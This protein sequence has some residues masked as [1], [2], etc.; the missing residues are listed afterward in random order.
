MARAVSPGGHSATGGPYPLTCRRCPEG[1]DG[2]PSDHSPQGSSGI[3]Q[4]SASQTSV[5]LLLLED[6]VA[7]MLEQRKVMLV[8]TGTRSDVTFGD[9]SQVCVTLSGASGSGQSGKQIGT[10]GYIHCREPSITE[11]LIQADNSLQFQKL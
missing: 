1:I 7:V 11:L 6:R 9:R 5:W 3:L 10:S 2:V 8:P 4:P